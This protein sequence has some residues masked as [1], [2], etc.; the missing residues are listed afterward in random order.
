MRTQRQPR[1][2]RRTLPRP[3][4]RPGRRERPSAK[5]VLDLLLGSALLLL[6]SPLLAAGALALAARR[7][8]GGVLDRSPRTGL[9]GRVFVL[10]SLRT[11]RLRLDVLSRLPHVVRGDLSL[12]GPEPLPPYEGSGSPV[13]GG[14][15]TRG[16]I[17]SPAARHWRLELKPGLTGL[18]QVRSRS[19]MPWDEPDLLDQYYAEHH[20][21]GL[22]LAVLV[23]AAHA[24]LHR[25][26]RALAR[27]GK[28]RLS[29]T[30][31]RRCGYSPPEEVDSVSTD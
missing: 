16:A 10:H 1:N 28:A 31:H 26:V 13:Q 18:A 15:C 27:R 3:R 8:P 5:R 24:P 7:P 29:D 20:H 2:R 19:G 4:P 11:R 6:A 30:D 12:V 14:T 23:R 17:A 9:G 22:D 25:T 21:M